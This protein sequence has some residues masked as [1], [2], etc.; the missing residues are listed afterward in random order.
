MPNKNIKTLSPK[1]DVVFQALFGEKGNERITKGFLEKILDR[2]IDK[3]DLDKNPILRREFK[4]EKLGV[5]DILAELDG[6][7]KC[8][9]ELQIVDR[10][11]IRE[12]ILYYW[13]RLYSRQIKAGQDYKELEK[14]I[15]IVITDF[16]IENLEELGYHSTW[17]IMETKSTKKIILTKKLEIDIIELP[18]IEG[19]EEVKD[20]LLD[21]LYFLEEPKGER[22]TKNMEENEEL[23]EAVE[24]LDSL[25]AD[26][27]MQR[28]AELRE[29]A[30]MDEKAIYARGLE[31]GERKGIEEKIKIVKM[32][33]IKEMDVKDIMVI[34]GLTEEEIGKIDDLTKEEREKMQ[35]IA[36]LREKAIMDEK[37]IYAKGLDVGEKR[38]I[39]KGL[40]EKQREIAK[41]ML[42]ENIS[43]DLI[44]KLTELTKEEIEKL[45]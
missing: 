4:D 39:E 41:K 35:R 28:I 18:K 43:I 20:E 27:R 25:S 40:K 19:K 9:I 8:N 31:I 33:L 13:S 1:I 16:K 21:W 7:E 15:V 32:M 3:I 37:A 29:K 30:I 42:E 11:N 34:T 45:I 17:Q 38:G 24:K 12:R 22:V 44:V 36:D 10:K 2:K 26:E 6:K 23:K 5:L 14:T